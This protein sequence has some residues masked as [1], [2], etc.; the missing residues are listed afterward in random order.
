MFIS[1]ETL[2]SERTLFRRFPCRTCN[3]GIISRTPTVFHS[4]NLSKYEETEFLSNNTN[5]F[6]NSTHVIS[7][8]DAATD[9]DTGCKRSKAFLSLLTFGP[10]VQGVRGVNCNR[11][12]GQHGILSHLCLDP[13][14]DG[15][16]QSQY[17]YRNISNRI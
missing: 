8:N 4:D 12:G 9:C 10:L 13:E 6:P 2:P 17:T 3:S 5:D 11:W 1:I 14:L 15:Q 7:S 16:N